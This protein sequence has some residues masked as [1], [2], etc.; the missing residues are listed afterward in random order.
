MLGCSIVVAQHQASG[1][2]D[3]LRKDV[4]LDK[5]LEGHEETISKNINTV[6][7]CDSRSAQS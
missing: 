1:T 4:K 7:V 6:E 5:H 2:D 3:E